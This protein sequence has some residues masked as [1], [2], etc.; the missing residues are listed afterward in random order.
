[1]CRG[2]GGNNVQPGEDH[3]QGGS[4]RMDRAG[5]QRVSVYISVSGA[6]TRDQRWEGTKCG[7]RNW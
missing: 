1:M 2:L 5:S 4:G 6:S 3:E 7:L